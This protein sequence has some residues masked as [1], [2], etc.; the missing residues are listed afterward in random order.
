MLLLEEKNHGWWRSREQQ[1]SHYTGW[2]AIFS[3]KERMLDRKGY[4]DLAANMRKARKDAKRELQRVLS[5][6]M[7]SQEIV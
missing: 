1:I 5:V 6:P 7:K 4:H 3:Q 2:M